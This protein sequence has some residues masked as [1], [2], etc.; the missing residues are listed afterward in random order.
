MKTRLLLVL[1][2]AVALTAPGTASAEL[3]NVSVGGKIEIYGAW[4]SA[5]FEPAGS[6]IRIPDGYLAWR[7]VG[8]MGTDSAVR[9]GH[10]GNN[11]SFLEQRT[12]VNVAADF[13]GNVRAFIEIDSIDTWGE[14]FRSNYITGG[15]MRAFT[16]N[17]VEVYQ[18][19][20]EASEMF[21]LPLQLRIGRQEL[22][23]GSG[24]LVGADPG[25][26]PFVGLSFD[27]VRL[28]Y[29][30]NST[31]IDVFWAKVME[32]M[33][34]EEDGDT[35]F[36]GIYAS[37]AAIENMTF[38]AY[39]FFLRDAVDIEDNALGPWGE[40]HDDL[41]DV[42]DYDHTEI[43]TLGLRWAGGIGAID[44]ELEGAYQFGEAAT[45]G[46]LFVPAG[47]IYG[48]D[49]ADYD[50]WAAHFE[51]G[52]SP[53]IVWTPRIYFGGSYYSGEDNRDVDFADFLNPFAKREASLSFNR[54]Y[55]SWR[56]DDII[57]GSAMSNFWK[58]YLGADLSPTD[59]ITLMMKVT[60]LEVVETFDSVA[61][62]DMHPIDQ[63]YGADW[64]FLP[65]YLPWV[66]ESGDDDLGWQTYLGIGYQYSEDLYFELGY[67][68]YFTGDAVADG[69]FIDAN[70]LGYVGGLGSNDADYVYAYTSIEF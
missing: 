16:G 31:T 42:D 45:L 52:Y 5:F 35:D 19:Y 26:D 24:W 27:A 44:W 61:H 47:F 64:L 49:D 7:P 21:G 56:E 9:A 57:D 10:G 23:F 51:V 59:K 17:D 63:L 8:V 67:T 4:Y 41:F 62:V 1:V 60:Y 20:I 25:P 70:G 32:L 2:L 30:L 13:T 14:D 65:P 50:A 33:T 22:E 66:T 48:D 34:A 38:D 58:L 53:D 15:D 18:A 55:S 39:W 40:W 43:H 68:H 28:T 37:C 54:L 11:L 6:A 69:A 12:R 46:A 36:Y 3:Q 29:Q